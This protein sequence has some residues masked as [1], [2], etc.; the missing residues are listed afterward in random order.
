MGDG[1]WQQKLAISGAIR[2]VKGISWDPQGR[3]LLSTRYDITPLFFRRVWLTGSLD[4]TTRMYGEWIRDGKRSWHEVARPQIHGYDLNAIS[5]LD[6]WKFVSGADEKV[7]RIFQTSRST[8]D[9]VNRLASRASDTE[10]PLSLP[11][12]FH[13]LLLLDFLVSGEIRANV[14]TS[15]PQQT[16]LSWAS[17]T[18]NPLPWTISHQP[19]SQPFPPHP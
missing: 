19:S 4:Q 14:R 2:G 12:P 1:I 16:S 11:T 10:V 15:P 7:L 9:L 5:S 3:Y 8:A 6:E 13:S 17:Q 18:K